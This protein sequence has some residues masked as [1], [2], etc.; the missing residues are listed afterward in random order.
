MRSIAKAKRRFSYTNTIIEKRPW[1]DKTSA[2]RNLRTCLSKR[3]PFHKKCPTG[4]I[5][6]LFTRKS[7]RTQKRPRK[8]KRIVCRNP[9]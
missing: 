7:K 4:K 3:K 8:T 9:A 6:V 1:A 2:E 5:T